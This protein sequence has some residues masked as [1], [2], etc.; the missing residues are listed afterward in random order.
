M[1]Q[2]ECNE[3]RDLLFE[4]RFETG[5]KERFF[6]FLAV[7]P[8]GM[9]GDT[10]ATVSYAYAP[11][12]WERNG[13]GEVDAYDSDPVVE[14]LIS[15]TP[16]KDRRLEIQFFDYL[17]NWPLPW[18]ITAK[19]SNDNFPT[20]VL[21]ERP[22]GRVEGVLMRDGNT[23][24]YEPRIAEDC[25]EPGEVDGL[26]ARLRSLGVNEKF[27][28]LYKESDLT[29]DTLDSALA[30]TPETDHGQK[31]VMIYRDMEWF[32]G[33]W[34]NPSKPDSIP[35]RMSSVADFH[36]SR[37]SKAKRGSRSGLEMA[38]QKQTIPGDYTILEHVLG[39]VGPVDAPGDGDHENHP[40]VRML[41]MWWNTHAP[42]AMRFAGTFRV[43][44]WM[45]KD[46]IFVAGD[47]E[48]PAMQAKGLAGVPCYSLFERNGRPTIAIVFA[49]G[50]AFNVGDS[51]GTKTFYANGEEESEIG[52][53]LDL[54][55]E[56]YYAVT[57]LI[58]ARRVLA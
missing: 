52:L 26:I 37:V 58:E 28:G 17:R 16:F 42:E 18:G 3:L 33:I 36:G 55:D 47:P 56:A 9:A 24:C 54:V 12:V 20:L 4:N 30:M 15:K 32:H 50:K 44:F 2:L 38:R 5:F 40:A 57:G 41:C 10:E 7:Q 11:A 14:D 23:H 45:G 34:N 46:R 51:S 27:L 31:Q 25:A 53:D 35:F 1:D 19:D 22:G 39:L 29:A 43:Y 48:E 6:R 13:K 8:G 21:V 49:R